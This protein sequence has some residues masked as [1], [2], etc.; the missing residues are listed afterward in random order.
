MTVTSL[1]CWD[2]ERVL[3]GTRCVE[4]S[5]AVVT[6]RGRMTVLSTAVNAFHGRINHKTCAIFTRYDSLVLTYRVVHYHNQMTNPYSSYT[7]CFSVP[8]HD[9]IKSVVDKCVY[10]HTRFLPRRLVRRNVLS[11]LHWLRNVQSHTAPVLESWVWTPFGYRFILAFFSVCVCACVCV[12][13]MQIKALRLADFLSKESYQI[14]ICFH[15][16][17]SISIPVHVARGRNRRLAF[18]NTV[19]NFQVLWI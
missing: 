6:L 4:G 18:L 12:C 19:I 8:L 10:H 9:K 5:E 13:C 15:R 7:L 16:K 17:V 2:S 14:S 3:N 11:R 1:K